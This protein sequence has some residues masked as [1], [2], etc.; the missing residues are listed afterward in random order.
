MNKFLFPYLLQMNNNILRRL[1]LLSPGIR[2]RI[3]WWLRTNV[4]EKTVAFVFNP[5]SSRIMIEAAGPCKTLINIDQ[6]KRKR[7]PEESK[8]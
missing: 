1:C 8:L 4:S 3:V 2:R 7:T 5:N 6:T